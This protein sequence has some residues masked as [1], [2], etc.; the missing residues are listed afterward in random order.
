MIL[1]ASLLCLL[2]LQANS[3]LPDTKTVIQWSPSCTLLFPT[4]VF[5]H[6]LKTEKIREICSWANIPDPL[7]A[8]QVCVQSLVEVAPVDLLIAHQLPLSYDMKIATFNLQSLCQNCCVLF[9]FFNGL[10]RKALFQNM[11]EFLDPY[12]VE[13]SRWYFQIFLAFRV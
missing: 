10:M 11:A 8:P 9:L 6:F 12:Y 4:S 5:D 3:S 13:Y 2:V 1:I 7:G